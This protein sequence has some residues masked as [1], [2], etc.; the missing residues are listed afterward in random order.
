MEAIP[1]TITARPASRR[2]ARTSAEMPCALSAECLRDEKKPRQVPALFH[3]YR[4]PVRSSNDNPLH[5]IERNYIGR[6][7]IKLRCARAL[8]RGHGLGVL[9]RAAGGCSGI[10]NRCPCGARGTL[11]RLRI[12]AFRR[13]GRAVTAAAGA[14]VTFAF[15]P[16]TGSSRLVCRR[17]P[18]K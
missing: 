1:S 16:D 2:I 13:R 14:D 11:K 7:V 10:S 17:S 15:F 4:L 8:V 5:L 18:A 3:L 9:K 6:A 12:Y